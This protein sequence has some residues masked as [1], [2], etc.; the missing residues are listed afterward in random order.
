MNDLIVMP[1]MYETITTEKALELCRHFGLYHLVDRILDHPQA[2]KPWEFDGCSWYP[3]KFFWKILLIGKGK[4]ITYE[5]CLPH[6]LAY[7]YGEDIEGERLY[8]DRKLYSDL[9]SKA[10]MF[11]FI[12]KAF[13]AMV[14][15]VGGPS[16]GEDDSR[17]N[18]LTDFKWKF[19]QK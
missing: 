2:Y 18:I 3:D 9:I 16:F 4:K 6:D 10:K 5:C 15:I 12:A 13:Y 11:R 19:A 7:A 1:K 14:R 8:A 17:D